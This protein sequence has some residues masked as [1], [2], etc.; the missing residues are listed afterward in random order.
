MR[1][2][3][4]LN[5]VDLVDNELTANVEDTATYNRLRKTLKEKGMIELPVVVKSTGGKYKIV[6][7]HHRLR[8]W[9]DEGLG[10]A[11]VICYDKSDLKVKSKEDEFNLVNNFNRVRGDFS[12]VKA[13]QIIARENLDVT[14]LDIFKFQFPNIDVVEAVKKANAEIEFKRKLLELAD[15]IATEIAVDIING[16]D[17]PLLVMVTEEYKVALLVRLHGVSA[18][19]VRKK[20]DVVIK[21]IKGAIGDD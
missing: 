8:A 13:N 17:E 1:E 18:A 6:S 15:K 5:E 4:H 19:A 2:I 21:A 7:G 12:P 16:I 9:F 20:G 14:K 3:I 10:P 11:P